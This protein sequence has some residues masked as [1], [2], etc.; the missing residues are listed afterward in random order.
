MHFIHDMTG[1]RRC[2]RGLHIDHYSQA[3]SHWCHL[4]HYFICVSE[5]VTS[6]C[7]P[8]PKYH[9]MYVYYWGS[10]CVQTSS[11]AHSASYTMDT[12]GPFPAG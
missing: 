1:A 4:L 11:E 3:R 8:T 6:I 12:R 2:T 5:I 9:A 7:A 10:L